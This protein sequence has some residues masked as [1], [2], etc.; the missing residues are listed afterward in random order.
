MGGGPE[1][2]QATY[3][4][5]RG[6]SRHSPTETSFLVDAWKSCFRDGIAFTLAPRTA[7]GAAVFDVTG[8]LDQLPWS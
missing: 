7:A 5:L 1:G 2:D 8:L 3:D 4:P 6:S